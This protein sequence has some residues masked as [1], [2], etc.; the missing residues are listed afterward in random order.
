MRC[1]QKVQPGV[2]GTGMTG[3][4]KK[5]QKTIKT[6]KTNWRSRRSNYRTCCML[7]SHTCLLYY[8]C[9]IE[10]FFKRCLKMFQVLSRCFHIISAYLQCKTS[11]NSASAPNC[12]QVSCTRA[13]VP[14]RVCIVFGGKASII[15]TAKA[16][17]TTRYDPVKHSQTWSQDSQDLSK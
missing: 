10:W 13:G 16:P 8:P 2:I 7:H 3:P 14:S 15:K 17:T 12:S 11:L 4:N 6:E 9:S 1:L 5:H